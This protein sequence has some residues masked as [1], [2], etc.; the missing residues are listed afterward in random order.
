MRMVINVISLILILIGIAAYYI[1]GTFN[2]TVQILVF[3]AVATAIISSYLR[4]SK[5]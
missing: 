2:F 5:K 4:L 1:Q 3:S